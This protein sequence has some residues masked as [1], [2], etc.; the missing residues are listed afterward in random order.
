MWLRLLDS[1][2]FRSGRGGRSGSVHPGVPGAG[3]SEGRTGIR[4]LVS[5]DSLGIHN[6]YLDNVALNG[7]DYIHPGRAQIYNGTGYDLAAKAMEYMTG[8]S[9]VRLS[10]EDLFRP[11]GINDVPVN[12]CAFGGNFTA[13]EL[14]I[15]GQCLANH[16][17]YGDKQLISEETFQ[18]L[19]PVPLSKY[20]PG[21]DL[22]WGIGLTW[23]REQKPGSKDLIFGEHVIGHGSASSCILRVD[24]DNDLVIAQIRK[25]AGEKYD[26]YSEKFFTTIADSLL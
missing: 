14:G 6:P 10:H 11:M 4:K 19:L 16:G 22:E 9:I 13:H 1:R 7:L 24:P 8:K 23:F 5:A 12:D 21:L 15:L 25:T 18:Q 17:R 26:E 20:Y 3:K 2:G